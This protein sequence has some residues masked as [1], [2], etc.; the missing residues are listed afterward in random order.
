[1]M[2]KIEKYLCPFCGANIEHEGYHFI[3]RQGGYQARCCRCEGAG[4]EGNRT[5]ELAL[6]AFC[7]PAH[8]AERMKAEVV[9]EPVAVAKP[10]AERLR[11]AAVG[12]IVTLDDGRRVRV[13]EDSNYLRCYKCAFTTRRPCDV[14]FFCASCDR[15]DNINVYFEEVRDE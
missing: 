13:V 14:E 10:E 7:T 15:R 12:S 2:E 6:T 4:P 9:P 8:F 11:D 3:E 5:K 1:M